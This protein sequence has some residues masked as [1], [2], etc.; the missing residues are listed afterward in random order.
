M[1][2]VAFRAWGIR[3]ERLRDLIPGY[4]MRHEHE[5]ASE[6]VCRAIGRATGYAVVTCSPQGTSLEHGKAE[7]NHFQLTLGT[8]IPRRRGGGFSVEGTVWIAVPV[9][10]A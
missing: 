10:A 8:P 4:A 6:A 9:G 2:R 3:P 7:S 5:G 1:K